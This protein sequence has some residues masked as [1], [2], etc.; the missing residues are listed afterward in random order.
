MSR[1]MKRGLFLLVYVFALM[2][3]GCKTTW[4]NPAVER[5]E[6]DSPKILSVA[7]R[8]TATVVEMEKQIRYGFTIGDGS[9]LITEDMTSV[10]LRWKSD[11]PN[12]NGEYSDSTILFRLVFEAVAKGTKRLDFVEGPGEREFRTWG[13][14]P[15][16]K[17]VSD[18][19]YNPSVSKFK[20]EDIP[21][22]RE[23]LSRHIGKVIVLQL[24]DDIEQ[25]ENIAAVLSTAK[26]RDCFV[27]DARISFVTIA[28]P[29]EEEY[30]EGS[31]KAIL[32]GKTAAYI[33]YLSNEEY[34][35]FASIVRPY[36]SKNKM[37]CLDQ[38]LQILNPGLI[39]NSN[40]H[41]EKQLE[42]L[43]NK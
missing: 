5:N 32:L 42:T 7:F 25:P 40:T 10:P 1:I 34:N 6:N 15:K 11:L 27:N 18:Y 28:R 14:R 17:K 21:F 12:Y 20:E 29:N 19:T 22:L 36:I 39:I 23:I 26:A 8:D 24:F 3:V 9:T 38:S 41:L 2:C 33:E 31:T 35:K 43:T 30:L 13:I 16:G 37:L 4:N